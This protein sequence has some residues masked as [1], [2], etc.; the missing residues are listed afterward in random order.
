[1]GL[2][3]AEDDFG[4]FGMDPKQVREDMERRDAQ[5]KEMSLEVVRNIRRPR[6]Q[7]KKQKITPEEYEKIAHKHG[8]IT[9]KDRLKE[10]G[11]F[12]QRDPCV[13]QRSTKSSHFSKE[14]FILS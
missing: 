5:Y 9:L 8:G 7:K 10:Q 3:Q 13:V 1:M 6:K 11:D 2:N 4:L 14:I 12:A